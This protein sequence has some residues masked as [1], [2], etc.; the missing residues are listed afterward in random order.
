ME[1]V[2]C[3]KRCLTI[4]EEILI[5]QFSQGLILFD[6]MDVWF[7]KHD[8]QNKKDILHNLLNMVIQSHA[9]YEEIEEPQN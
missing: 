9:T 6:E 3:M 8:L 2:I 4:N 5:N 1:E 7:K